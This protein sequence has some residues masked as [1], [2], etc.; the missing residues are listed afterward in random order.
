MII[1]ER[2]KEVI[3]T[4]LKAY[5]GKVNAAKTKIY[6]WNC[7]ARTMAKIARTLGYEGNII[8]NSFIYLG[9]RIHKG[10]KKSRLERSGSKNKE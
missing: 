1:V 8:W 5:D 3:S 7:P 10:S 6:G 4:F 2:F 9:I